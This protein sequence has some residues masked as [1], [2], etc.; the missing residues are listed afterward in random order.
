MKTVGFVK[1]RTHTVTVS[2]NEASDTIHC[3]KHNDLVSD[4][5]TF[6]TLDQEACCEWIITALPSARWQFVEGTDQS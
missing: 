2:Y 5:A 4:W 6:D 1:F 3:F